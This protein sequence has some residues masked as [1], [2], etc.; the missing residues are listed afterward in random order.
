MYFTPFPPYPSK[1]RVRSSILDG[2]PFP[3]D[4]T[5]LTPMDLQKATWVWLQ[6]AAS[7]KTIEALGL[8]A[9]IEP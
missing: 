5:S 3:S 6:L 8:E 7:S 9:S 2:S 4:S 1:T